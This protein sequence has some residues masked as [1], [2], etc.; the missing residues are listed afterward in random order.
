MLLEKAPR[1]S[2]F[3]KLSENAFMEAFKKAHIKAPVK[4]YQKSSSEKAS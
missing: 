1:N 3:E 4:A 2:S